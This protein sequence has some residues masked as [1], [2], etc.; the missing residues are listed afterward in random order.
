[1]SQRDADEQDTIAELR[2]ELD[3]STS[4]DRDGT[5]HDLLVAAWPTKRAQDN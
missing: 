3:A 4:E 2:D 1:M 5:L